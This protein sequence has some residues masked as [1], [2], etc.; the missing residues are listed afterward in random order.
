MITVKLSPESAQ[1]VARYLAQV[2]RLS[3]PAYPE[4]AKQA[5]LN[6]LAGHA[7]MAAIAR[8]ISDAV[9]EGDRKAVIHGQAMQRPNK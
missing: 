4:A 6:E 9:R 7:G 1:V 2:D 8:A 5:M 3:D